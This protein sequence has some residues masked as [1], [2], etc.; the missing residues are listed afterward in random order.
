MAKKVAVTYT[1]TAAQAP[2][3]LLPLV[4]EEELAAR[5]VNWKKCTDAGLLKEVSVQGG[6]LELITKEAS[7]FKEEVYSNGYNHPPEE[8]EDSTE[9]CVCLESLE[10]E[11]TAMH[12]MTMSRMPTDDHFLSRLAQ[13]RADADA[14]YDEGEEK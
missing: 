9:E 1:D 2:R 11:V 14:S 3:S 5:K 13:L 4:I 8:D 7:A 6:I 12:T 10:A